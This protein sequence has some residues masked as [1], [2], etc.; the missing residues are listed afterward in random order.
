[1][2]ATTNEITLINALRNGEEGAFEEVYS[3]YYKMA[4]ITP[5]LA[6]TAILIE[7]LC[8][9]CKMADFYSYHANTAT[10]AKGK[11]RKSIC[12]LI[13]IKRV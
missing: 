7:L 10:K 2:N 1:M 8:N 5:K 12:L 4:F 13:E 3:K 6:F 11:K 9:D